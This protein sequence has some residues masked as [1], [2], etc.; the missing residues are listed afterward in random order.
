MFDAASSRGS[1]NFVQGSP[2]TSR[3][4]RRNIEI[5]VRGQV[6]GYLVSPEERRAIR[7]KTATSGDSE[8]LTAL[9]VVQS[10]DTFYETLFIPV[11]ESKGFQ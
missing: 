1:Y 3:K 6:S 5:V 10:D 7:M 11:N 8:S 2:T 4:N 9:H